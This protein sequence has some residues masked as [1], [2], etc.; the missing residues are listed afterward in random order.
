M[1]FR[2]DSDDRALLAEAG[3]SFRRWLPLDRLLLPDDCL[4]AWKGL[5]QDGW[6]DV[7][8]GEGDDRLPLALIA[9]VGRE[10]GRV[11]AGDAFVSNAVLIRPVTRTCPSEDLTPGF[12]VSNGSGAGYHPT[13]DERPWS[14]GVE[15]GLVPYRL[16]ANGSLTR[17]TAEDWQL[18]PVACLAPQVVSTT[19]VGVA[20]GTVVGTSHDDEL[21][22]LTRARIVHA[23]ALVGLGEAMN[24]DAITYAKQRVQ[25]GVPIGRFQAVKHLLAES[26]VSLE[27][28]WNA[29]LY[30]AL[31][32][33]EVA[34]DIAQIQAQRAVDLAS[35]IATQVFAGVAITWEHHLHVLVK[36]AQTSRMRFGSNDRIAGRV[37]ARLVK[38]GSLA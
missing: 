17:F 30:A 22:L 34:A 5:S 13:G 9:G 11:A 25:F 20:D 3:A 16:D 8:S 38:E 28:A 27:V 15:K 21:K 31:R 29:T 26:S 19:R 6:L 37:G 10:A 4:W 24:A 32:P 1:D 12:L 2:Y 14:F 35:R 33:S 7:A 18:E 36:C 23:A